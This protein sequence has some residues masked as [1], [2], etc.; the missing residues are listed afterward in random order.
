M[1]QITVGVPGQ[2]MPRDSELTGYQSKRT[3][4]GYFC[5]SR[6]E[7]TTC[8]AGKEVVVLLLAIN[9]QQETDWDEGGNQN[10]TFVTLMKGR[11]GL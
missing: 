9:E 8:I 1:R 5:R 10:E 7:S 2:S 11:N 6:K 3:S 4:V